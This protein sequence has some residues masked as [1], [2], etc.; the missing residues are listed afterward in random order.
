MVEA[1]V[2]GP[3]VALAPPA[4]FTRELQAGLL[5]QAFDIEVKTG[6]YRLAWLKSKRLSPGMQLFHDWIRAQAAPRERCASRACA[7]CLR[8][9]RPRPA[10]KRTT[11]GAQPTARS[12]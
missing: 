5:V 12:S 8:Q 6:S 11:T 9:D 3:G 2:Q 1:A 4:M 7:A 10:R